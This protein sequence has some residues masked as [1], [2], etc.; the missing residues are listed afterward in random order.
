MRYVIL[1]ALLAIFLVSC[2]TTTSPPSNTLSSEEAQEICYQVQKTLPTIS[3]SDTYK[4][5]EE[6]VRHRILVKAIC[7]N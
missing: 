4:T 1:V 7:D 5:K 6:V 3:E 2:N